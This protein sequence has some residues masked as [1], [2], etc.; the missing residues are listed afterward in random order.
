[1]HSPHPDLTHRDRAARAVRALVGAAEHGRGGALVITGASGSEDDLPID[2]T[3]ADGKARLPTRVVRIVPPPGTSGASIDHLFSIDLASLVPPADGPTSGDDGDR[4][5]RDLADV[6]SIDT[7]P[8]NRFTFAV[9]L[10]R[11]LTALADHGPIMVVVDHAELLDDIS[12]AALAFVARRISDDPIAIII[13]RTASARVS[14]LDDLTLIEGTPRAWRTTESS[15]SDS[16]S[17]PVYSAAD[18]AMTDTEALLTAA[19]QALDRS[20]MDSAS[21]AITALR[22]TELHGVDHARLRL[23]Q[24]RL[25]LLEGDSATA[26]T[27]LKEAIDATASLDTPAAVRAATGARLLLVEIYLRGGRVHLASATANELVTIG[28]PAAELAVAATQA[29]LGDGSALAKV[30]DLVDQV[31]HDG[32]VD[33]LGFVADTAGL[34][35]VWSEQYEE[36]DRLLTRLARDARIAAALGPLP[37]VLAVQAMSDLRQSR[38]LSASIRADEA[39]RLA[40]AT[41][42]PGMASFPASVLAVSEAVRGDEAGCRLATSRLVEDAVRTERQGGSSATEVPARAAMGLLHLG[43]DRP[44]HAIAHLEPLIT[45]TGTTPWHVLWQVDLAE[46]FIR[47]GR[48]DDARKLTEAFISGLGSVRNPRARAAAARVE[49]LL[50]ASTDLAEAELLLSG[51]E[52]MLRK[53][54]PALSLARTLLTRG[55][56]RRS[57]GRE[58]EAGNDLGEAL[59]MFT[60]FGASGWA[61]QTR[62]DIRQRSDSSTGPAPVSPDARLTPFE[63]QVCALVASPMT[64]QETADEL[65]VSA[66]SVE[67]NLGRIYEKLA[68]S[69]RR[70]LVARADQWGLR[71][72]H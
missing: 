40:D 28:G 64:N 17:T 33:A 26:T 62:R 25:A 4:D 54:G 53:F 32:E 47:C 37:R 24:A 20:L 5:R 36:A 29:A 16:A 63:L 9:Q 57:A 3:D 1:M 2:L 7:E 50:C 13:R 58:T 27:R 49:A 11:V 56:I 31:I 30:A 65:F 8:P 10:H 46:A 41:A 43:L 51:S 21:I 45:L 67:F 52:Q 35:L 48:T 19:E 60:S 34:G 18:P 66:R 22:G 42:R 68:I 23:S 70:Q 72:A 38:Y 15:R 6:L 71:G 14:P 69:S 55:R 12:A 39:V 59:A 61:G 44:E